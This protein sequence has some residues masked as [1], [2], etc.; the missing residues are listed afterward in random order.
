MVDEREDVIILEDEEGNEHQF[1]I[2]DVFEMDDNR[3]AV[4]QAV[5]N[6][7]EAVILKVITEDGEDILVD[8]EDDEEFDRAAE[9]WEASLEA[10][11]FED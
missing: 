11:D 5:D 3:Y 7:E 6:E 10:E 9:Y 2:I 4:L 1:E 8:I